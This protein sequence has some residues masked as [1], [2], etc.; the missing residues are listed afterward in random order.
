MEIIEY[1]K[2]DEEPFECD[3][4]EDMWNAMNWVK[5]ELFN[6][7]SIEIMLCDKCYRKLKRK[8]AE[9]NRNTKQ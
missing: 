5:L 6:K 7:F 4:C 9:M 3:S 2:Q 1:G 8:I